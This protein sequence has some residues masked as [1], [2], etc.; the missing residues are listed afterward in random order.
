MRVTHSC[1]F[2]KNT[3]FYAFD[4]SACLNIDFVYSCK[5]K[6]AGFCLRVKYLIINFRYSG[7][8]RKRRDARNLS[9]F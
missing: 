1:F 5:K 3:L 6:S 2:I 9:T 7:H 8:D 4:F